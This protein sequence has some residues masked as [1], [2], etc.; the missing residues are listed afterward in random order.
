M[1]RHE[2]WSHVNRL[3]LI[4]V[5]PGMDILLALGVAWVRVDKQAKEAK[6][7]ISASVSA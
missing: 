4:Y 5:A 2:L 3:D 7:A 1:S 6:T